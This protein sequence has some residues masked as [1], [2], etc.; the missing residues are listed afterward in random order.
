MNLNEVHTCGWDRNRQNVLF[1][2]TTKFM[3]RQSRIYCFLFNTNLDD[4]QR[5]H[6]FESVRKLNQIRHIIRQSSLNISLDLTQF[7]QKK[8]QLQGNLFVWCRK[9]PELQATLLHTG[10]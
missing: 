1:H 5:N 10:N 6:L 9:I 7:H 4:K 3:G 8:L 2:T